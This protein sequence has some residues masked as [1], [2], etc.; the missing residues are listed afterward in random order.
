MSTGGAWRLLRSQTEAG[1]A[2]MQRF[3]EYAKSIGCVTYEDG[4]LCDAIEC[5]HEQS[6]MLDEWWR[7]NTCT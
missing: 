7:A 3:H 1:M 4:P 6:Q 2:L 5:D